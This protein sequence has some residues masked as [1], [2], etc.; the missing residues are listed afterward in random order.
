MSVYLHGKSGRVA[1][2]KRYLFQNQGSVNLVAHKKVKHVNIVC[3]G[4]GPR[5]KADS[6]SRSARATRVTPPRTAELDQIGVIP[7]MAHP[8]AGTFLADST[9]EFLIKR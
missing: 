5:S 6:S 9:A 8:P 1:K 3:N 7:S 2:E 4:G